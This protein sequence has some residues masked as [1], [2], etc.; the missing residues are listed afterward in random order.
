MVSFA[1]LYGTLFIVYDKILGIFG[2]FSNFQHGI[3]MFLAFIKLLSEISFFNFHTFHGFVYTEKI[4]D[5]FS[6][7][8]K[9]IMFLSGR[10]ILK[11]LKLQKIIYW[12]KNRS[13]KHDWWISLSFC[14]VINFEFYWKQQY[15]NFNF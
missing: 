1:Q 5:C 2:T 10:G 4:Y 14:D 6:C 3:T 9:F 12:F 15:F 8:W 13:N 7:C 11:C